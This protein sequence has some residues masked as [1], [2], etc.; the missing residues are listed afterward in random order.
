MS[1]LW[2]AYIAATPVAAFLTWLW[3]IRP[4]GDFFR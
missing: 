1:P 2:V 4:I 3:E